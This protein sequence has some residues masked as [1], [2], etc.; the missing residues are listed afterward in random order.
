MAMAAENFPGW[1]YEIKAGLRFGAVFMAESGGKAVAFCSGD[2]T[3]P[4]TFGPMGTVESARGRGL[5]RVLHNQTLE[6]MKKRGR[7]AARIPWVGPIPFYARLSG[8]K[9]GPIYW[10]FGKKV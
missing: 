8:A 6:F 1:A 3:N 7:K 4:G 5:A 2:G 10:T 9:L